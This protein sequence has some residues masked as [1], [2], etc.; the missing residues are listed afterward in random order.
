MA[1]VVADSFCD[2]NTKELIVKKKYDRFLIRQQYE[3]TDTNG[4]LLLKVE[5]SSLS[6]HKKRVMRDASGSLVLTM[7]QKVK[8]ATLRHR[9]RIHRGKSSEKKDLIFR[10][11]RSHPLEMKA[12]LD[13]FMAEHGDGD[14]DENIN[15]TSSFQLV[16][17]YSDLSCRVYRGD[18]VI[19]QVTEGLP[20]RSF[21]N[22][23]E[24]FRVKINGGVDYAFIFALL[25]MFTVNDY[26]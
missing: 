7:R 22:F 21:F 20:T 12:H 16:K 1:S 15:K 25:V 18:G 4:K 14:D 10:V 6:L 26:I 5:G 17:T 9:W 24:S 11:E 8:L 13:A 2:A 23:K 3:L 19:A